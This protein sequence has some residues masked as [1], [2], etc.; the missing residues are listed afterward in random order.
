MKRLRVL[1]LNIWNKSGPWDGRLPLIRHALA[2]LEPDLVGFQEVLRLESAHICQAREIAEGL[3][4]EVA[5]A[6]A[7]DVGNGLV[8]GNAAL[9]RHPIVD[10]WHT[11][12]EVERPDD[13]RSLLHA[14]VR[15]PYGDVP[16]FVTHLSW[17]F[18]EASVRLRQARAIAAHVKARASIAGFPPV[19][20]G[21]FN[22][23]ADSDEVRYLTGRAV[24]E[25]ES[26]YFAD[27]YA[28]RGE[29]PGH[30]WHPRNPFTEP[31]F[32]PARRID[33]VFVRGP[34]ER[35]RGRVLD[36]SVVCDVATAAGVFP[37]D[38]FGVLT[39]IQATPDVS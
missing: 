33:Y 14:L 19:L 12:L 7:L 37:S 26:T 16:F 28:W 3:D 23:D 39:D 29:P 35:G 22:A 6:P 36:A 8:L 15:T 20:V 31:A 38:H 2:A 24:I 13:G 17:R 11:S 25:G 5:F 21:D 1:T 27:A 34:D 9:S 30:T 4:Y 32:G 10:S 18:H